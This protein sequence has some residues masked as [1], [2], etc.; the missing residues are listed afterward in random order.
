V[1]D[2]A[3]QEGW[4]VLHY[5]HARLQRLNHFRDYHYQQVAL[6]PAA[7]IRISVKAAFATG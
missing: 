4:Y 2:V 6:I 7:G 5:D 3:S 1:A